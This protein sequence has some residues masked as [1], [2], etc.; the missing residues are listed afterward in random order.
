M[1][2]AQGLSIK[3]INTVTRESDAGN[4][5]ISALCIRDAWGSAPG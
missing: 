2:G 4:G 5:S 3:T 1:Q